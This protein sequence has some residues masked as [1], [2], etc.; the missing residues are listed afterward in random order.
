MKPTRGSSVSTPGAL[1]IFPR[2]GAWAEMHALFPDLPG[3]RQIVVL[4]VES[5]QTSCG[6][7]VPFYA[8]AGPR[9]VLVDGPEQAL[10]V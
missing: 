7:G 8:Y 1:F 5:L 9:P 4:A 10:R 2:D 6:F 3:E